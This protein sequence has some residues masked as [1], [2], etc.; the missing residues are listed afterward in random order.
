MACTSEKKTTTILDSLRQGLR[1]VWCLKLEP[2]RVCL[3]SLT[4]T[5]VEKVATASQRGGNEKGWRGRR[6]EKDGPQRLVYVPHVRKSEK[7]L[8]AI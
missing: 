1:A 2:Y 4:C 6:F 5:P 7:Y 8:L 3:V